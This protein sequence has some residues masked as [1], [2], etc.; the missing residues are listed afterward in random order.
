MVLFRRKYNAA[1]ESVFGKESIEEDI[2]N[3]NMSESI[4]EYCNDINNNNLINSKQKNKK[5]KFL[6]NEES[7]INQESHAIDNPFICRAQNFVNVLEQHIKNGYI[8]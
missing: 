7:S 1:F 3:I 4:I 6:I 5:K 8:H 2:G